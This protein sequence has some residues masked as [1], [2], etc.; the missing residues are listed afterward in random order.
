[1]HSDRVREIVIF[2]ERLWSCNALVGNYLD[3]ETIALFSLALEDKSRQV[4][5]KKTKRQ[6]K[7][8]Y[9]KSVF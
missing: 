7:Q 3:Q 9:L 6:G 5:M 2:L 4:G 8:T 1:M